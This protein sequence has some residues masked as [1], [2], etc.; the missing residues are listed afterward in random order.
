MLI[1]VSLATAGC[2]LEIGVV[3]QIACG[4][5]PQEKAPNDHL[6]LQQVA[7]VLVAQIEPS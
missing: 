7:T 1:P 6:L 2:L 4:E 3:T 5:P